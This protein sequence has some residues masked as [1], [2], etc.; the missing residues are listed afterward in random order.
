MSGVE[1]GEMIKWIVAA[2]ENLNSCIDDLWKGESRGVGDVREKVLRVKAY[3]R[4]GGEFL[5]WHDV[6]M[7]RFRGEVVVGPDYWRR[8]E[9]RGRENSAFGQC[10]L[11]IVHRS[12][13][14]TVTLYD[15]G[16]YSM[17]N[18]R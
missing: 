16:M 3:V 5:A 17:L 8:V 9:I 18:S 14:A 7:R 6:V 12:D 4:S 11:S 1:R 13:M 10:V 15:G 2:E